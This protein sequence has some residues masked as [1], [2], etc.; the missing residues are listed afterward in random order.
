[1]TGCSSDVTGEQLARLFHDSFEEL[2][3]TF[4]YAAASDHVMPWSA[5]TSGW[6]A[7]MV[8]TADRVLSELHQLP[9]TARSTGAFAD[10]SARRAGWQG[11][12]T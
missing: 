9:S 6:R 8:A 3:P 10:V 2:A 12:R 11:G 7:L 5:L 4:G 1:M